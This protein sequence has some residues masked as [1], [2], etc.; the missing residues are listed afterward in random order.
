MESKAHM[1]GSLSCATVASPP[2]PV[3]PRSPV[4]ATVVM[5]PGW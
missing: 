4:P 5:I 1:N 3:Y 2:S